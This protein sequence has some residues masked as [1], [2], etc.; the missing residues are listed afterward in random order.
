MNTDDCIKCGKCTGVC[1][2]LT[3]Y[4]TDLKDIENDRRELSYNCLMCGECTNVC[5]MNID[6]RKVALDIR[7][8]QVSESNFRKAS[9]KGIIFEK[10]DYLFKNYSSSDKNSVLFPGCN[11]PSF[12]PKTTKYLINLLKE[13]ADMGVGF[14]CC[15]KPIAELGMEKEEKRILD[16]IN[17]NLSD[18][19]VQEL[20]TMCPNC[21]HYLKGKID[22]EVIDIYEKLKNIGF[23]SQTEAKDYNFFLPC[24]D[25]Y[26]RDMLGSIKEIL[27][28]DSSIKPVDDV[29]CCGL[30]GLAI[31]TDRE[32]SAELVNKLKAKEFDEMYTYCATCYGNFMRNGV[33]NP[34][35]I[36]TEILGVKEEFP[37]G[38]K[39][40]L[41]R[42]K[43]GLGRS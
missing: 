35:H 18:N 9:Y 30:G 3:K 5:P 4:N 22:V 13:K 33:K 38:I 39:S 6:G 31:C 36:L 43:F 41:N 14:D 1:D 12:F 23:E 29:Q 24:P 34:V 19:K 2:F 28:V 32:V 11:F 8:E 17:K 25:R 10:K 40:V 26:K 15:G 37:K 16:R 21:Y 42:A 27:H 20:V 7:K